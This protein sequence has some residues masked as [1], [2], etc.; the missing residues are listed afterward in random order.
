MKSDCKAPTYK[1]LETEFEQA[2]HGSTINLRFN[3]AR[4]R[5]K[6]LE[7]ATFIIIL[8]WRLES[9]IYYC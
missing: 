9:D 7:S 3:I 5:A 4:H 6:R 1:G 8:I 2:R